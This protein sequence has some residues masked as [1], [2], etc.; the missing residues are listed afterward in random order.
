MSAPEP[1]CVLLFARADAAEAQ[2][3]GLGLRGAALFALTRRRVARAV[4]SLPGVALV[5]AGAPGHLRPRHVLPQRGASFG[6][7]LQAAVEDARALGYRQVVVVGLD[8]PRLGAADLAAAFAA[9]DVAPA[10]FGPSPDGGVYLV[11]VSG[12]LDRLGPVRWLGGRV[13]ADLRA[14]F[15]G[16]TWLA[17]RADVDGA[18]DAR[19]AARGDRAWASALSTLTALAVAQWPPPR[20]A[21]SAPAPRALGI[22]GPPAA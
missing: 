17:P 5:V 2:A 16:A 14:L 11:G 18:A 8:V 20:P 10:V 21:P 6:A 22:R 19:R 4:A 12:D 3:K 9:L 13:Q 7:R 1:R 15:P